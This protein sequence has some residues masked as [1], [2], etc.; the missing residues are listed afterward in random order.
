M[1]KHIYF[2]TLFFLTGMTSLSVKGQT[3]ILTAGTVCYN[4]NISIPVSVQNMQ[5]VFGYYLRLHYNSNIT[6]AGYNVLSP[7]VFN[8]HVENNS[9]TGYITMRVNPGTAPLN[10]QN[11][12]IYIINFK[13]DSSVTSTVFQWDSV[14]FWGQGGTLL[15][16]LQVNG[17]IMM[18]PIITQ[19][20]DS[21]SVCEN[22]NTTVTFSVQAI[23]SSLTY[24]WQVSLNN[25]S[26]WANL[27]NDVHYQG[28][29]TQTLTIVAPQAQ[30]NNNLYRCNLDGPC[31]VFSDVA[32]LEVF[33]N[34]LTQPHDTLINVGGTAVF[35]T[36]A[37][38]NAPT[39][40]WEASTDGG[41]TWSSSALFTPVTTPN[42]TIIGPPSSWSG[43]KFRCI[44]NGQCSP[45][46]TTSHIATLWVGTAGIDEQKSMAY[47]IYPNPVKDYLYITFENTGDIYSFL[48]YDLTGKQVIQM[49]DIKTDAFTVNCKNLKAGIYFYRL[50]D[51]KSSVEAI[52]KIILLPE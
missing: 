30:M 23:D 26:T 7:S 32:L 40:L 12:Y 29:N 37:T 49:N 33:S 11:G 41:T 19:Q 50:I 51:A 14:I 39:Y 31:S 17:A 15:Q 20:P 28:V 24:R 1:K 4:T 2:I 10:I 18:P 13:L 25:G 9:N 6:Y 8:T 42:I 43:Y 35:R 47:K 5:N 36:Q 48:F 27:I 3:P 44:V 22:P 16:S 34:I 45:P 38:G 46:A 21:Q 52:G